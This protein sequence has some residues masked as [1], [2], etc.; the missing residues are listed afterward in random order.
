MSATGTGLR[1]WSHSWV[2]RIS[3]AGTALLAIGGFVLSFAALRDLAV[4]VGMPA[5]LGWIWPL[6]IDGM[7]VEATLAVV[8]LAQRGSRAVWYAWFLLAVGA[9]VSVGS[10]GVHAMVTG[11]GWAGAAA[12]SVPPVVLLATTHLT[13]LLMAAPDAPDSTGLTGVPV[14]TRLQPGPDNGGGAPPH[15]VGAPVTPATVVDEA[16]E[17]DASVSLEPAAPDPSPSA[18]GDSELDELD[19]PAPATDI[20]DV[21]A[22]LSDAT[23]EDP[24]DEDAGDAVELSLEEWVAQH[25]AAGQ[26]VTGT[27]VA[28]RLGVSP[29]TGRR[30]LAAL[31]KARQ[32]HL[33]LASNE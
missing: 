27:M 19:S 26:A 8:A 9:V 24:Q 2:G 15:G 13:V 5:D 32:P 10:N 25:E 33:R 18:P 29:S 22:E 21:E 23:G 17:Q 28:E 12:A 7:I 30:R 16:K 6:L 20:T 1:S 31:R 3:V 14:E 4:R 11:H